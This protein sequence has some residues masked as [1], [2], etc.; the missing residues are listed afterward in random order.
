M[1]IAQITKYKGRAIYGIHRT[2]RSISNGER[3]VH[4]PTNILFLSADG[5]K[6]EQISENEYFELT[7]NHMDLPTWDYIVDYR[8]YN[9]FHG[10]PLDR[11]ARELKKIWS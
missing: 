8:K 7:A 3:T 9:A 2:V 1:I 5:K 4:V 6:Q 11:V 10:M